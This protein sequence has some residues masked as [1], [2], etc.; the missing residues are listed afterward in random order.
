M[1]KIIELTE[2]GRKKIEDCINAIKANRKKI[3]ESGDDTGSETPIPS[4]EDIVNDISI[5][6]EYE[7]GKYSYLNGW[8]ITDHYNVL[9]NLDRGTDYLVYLTKEELEKALKAGHSLEQIYGGFKAAGQ[10]C[11]IYKAPEWHGEDFTNFGDKVVYIPDVSLNDIQDC[12]EKLSETEIKNIIDHSYTQFDFVA[13]AY[14]NY[15]AG[16]EL[17]NFDDWE[18]PFVQDIIDCT[19]DEDAKSTYGETWEEMRERCKTDSN[20]KDERR[21]ENT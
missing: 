19:D 12:Y 17:F 11:D 2:E 14:W 16:E 1:N 21:L 20:I 4:M 6:D 9:L 13:E 10:E 5:Y 7:D 18:N 8:G 3:L 15:K